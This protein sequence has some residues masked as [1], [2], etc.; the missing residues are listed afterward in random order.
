MGIIR[1]DR[2]V[3]GD[4]NAICDLSGQKY[5]R[6]D[7]RLTWDNLLVGKEHWSPK[8]PQLDIRPRQDDP[9]IH[10]QTRTQG[11]DP[12]MEFPSFT[13]AQPVFPDAN[14][15]VLDSDANPFIVS[16]TVLDNLGISFVV[17]D[18]A[19]DSDGNSFTIFA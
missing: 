16:N 11:P 18:S 9:A 2:F 5:K 12:A 3:S 7:M 15:T 6:S 4:H 19:L 1:R 13:P 14:A 17:E 8:Q 10:N